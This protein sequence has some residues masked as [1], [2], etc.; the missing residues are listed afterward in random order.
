MKLKFLVAGVLAFLAFSTAGSSAFAD[1]TFISNYE[2]VLGTSLELKV[3]ASSR[4]A[5]DRAQSSRAQRDRTP[6]STS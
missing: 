3:G 2:N 4:V 5:A 1:R 6:V